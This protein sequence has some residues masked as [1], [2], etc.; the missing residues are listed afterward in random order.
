MDDLKAVGDEG[1]MLQ[2]WLRILHF[3]EGNKDARTLK[4]RESHGK[5]RIHK[6]VFKYQKLIEQKH[7]ML[8]RLR[9]VANNGINYDTSDWLLACRCANR[10]CPIPVN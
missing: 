8:C 9:Y 5:A 3:L 10:I 1:M 6:H 2:K 4:E 7:E